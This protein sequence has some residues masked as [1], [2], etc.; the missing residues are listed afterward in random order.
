K[1][2]RAKYFSRI[3]LSKGYYQIPVQPQVRKYL[4]FST[5]EGHFEFNVLP[6]G[7][8][9]APSIFSA[10][11]GKLL[12]PLSSEH[13]HS[14]MDDILIAT[15]TWEEHV[16]LLQQLLARLRDTGLTARPTKCQ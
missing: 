1:L 8:H 9:N 15:P 5:M 13:L 7:L 6:F 16:T 10:M 4:A 11:M 14:F 2:Q 12:A 3:D